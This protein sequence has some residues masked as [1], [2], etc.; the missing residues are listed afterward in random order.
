MSLIKRLV[1]GTPLT[2][3]EGDANLDFLEN[4]ANA[5]SSFATTG[6]NEFIGNQSIFGN[7]NVYGTS[8]IQYTTSSQAYIGDSLIVLST[9]L[10]SLRF[11]GISVYDS[12]S[13]ALSGSLFWDS[14]RQHWVYANPSGSTYDG[15]LIIS[16][17]K[18]TNGLGNEQ[19]LLNNVI[20]KGQGNDH[21]TSSALIEDGTTFTSK[22]N[23]VISG[24]LDVTGI[25][26]GSIAGSIASASYAQTSSYSVVSISSSFATTASY[27]RT[28]SF[29]ANAVSSFSATTAI[30]ASFATTA[31]SAS[32]ATTSTSASYV[33]NAVSSSYALSASVSQTASFVMTAQTASYVLNAVSSSYALSASVSQTASFVMTAQTASYVLNAVSSSYALSASY[34]I[35]SS[36]AVS[37]SN[38]NLLEGIRRSTLAT[39]GS[40]TFIG[41]QTINGILTVSSSVVINGIYVGAS[42]SNASPNIVL[43]SNALNNISI[44][45]YNTSM[46]ELTLPFLIT[47]SFNTALG[48]TA[49][50][51][52]Q[53][54]SYNTFLGRSS[55]GNLVT[56]SFNTFIGSIIFPTASTFNNTIIIADGAGSQRLF[57]SSSGLAIFSNDLYVSSSMTTSGS[58]TV[59]RSTAILSQVSQSFNF[60][61]DLAASGSGIPLGGLYH[62]S[63]TIKIRLV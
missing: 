31:I 25:I 46:G 5:T 48:Y 57:I 60:A 41:N 18:N 17:P 26:Y 2:F 38:A 32:F 43:G 23:T 58:L 39:T 40:N 28:A 22:V 36:N 45:A 62:T 35:S 37:S 16:G 24:S 4:L 1:K 52:L 51:D 29:V 33:L 13:S 11:G 12:G 3:A 15:G 20:T 59:Q 44:G 8:S 42:P 56:G 53:S 61:N 6:S 30:S 63:G 21:I 10:P 54:G 27:A 9:D 55:G 50:N 47:G 34:A 7:L 49:G 19:G 14:Q